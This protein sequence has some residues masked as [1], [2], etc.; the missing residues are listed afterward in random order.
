MTSKISCLIL[1]ATFIT[2]GFSSFHQE[3]KELFFNSLEKNRWE[4]TLPSKRNFSHLLD[5]WLEDHGVIKKLP[6]KIS[7]ASIKALQEIWSLRSSLEHSYRS[8]LESNT[9]ST[10]IDALRN[11]GELDSKKLELD[12]AKAKTTCAE[13]TEVFKK[14]LNEIKKAKLETRIEGLS[15]EKQAEAHETLESA[16]NKLYWCKKYAVE[17]QLDFARALRGANTDVKNI[18][19]NNISS[20][21]GEDPDYS[22]DFEQIPLLNIQLIAFLPI[23]EERAKATSGSKGIELSEDIT[24]AFKLEVLS[25]PIVCWAAEEEIMAWIEDAIERKIDVRLELSN[26]NQSVNQADS[27]DSKI[28]NP[29][30]AKISCPATEYLSM[31]IATFL[32]LEN[33]ID[34]Y[35]SAREELDEPKFT[36]KAHDIYLQT[37]KRKVASIQKELEPENLEAVQAQINSLEKNRDSLEKFIEDLMPAL[38]ESFS[39]H[40]TLQKAKDLA[41]L[42]ASGRFIHREEIDSTT[43]E[44]LNYYESQKLNEE[45]QNYLLKELEGNSSRKIARFKARIVKYIK[46][47]IEYQQKNPSD[48]KNE[49]LERAF[50]EFTY[51]SISY[52]SQQKNKKLKQNLLMRALNMFYHEIFKQ[53]IKLLPVPRAAF[54]RTFPQLQAYVKARVKLPDFITLKQILTERLMKPDSL[55]FS[56]PDFPE[57]LLF[58]IDLLQFAS[59]TKSASRID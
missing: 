12:I 46:L 39:L 55:K 17:A 56:Q 36:S 49:I 3:L 33:V 45:N 54:E 50:D 41:I 22:D 37:L 29:T 24:D 25:Q 48:K 7:L 28:N 58:M 38:R 43:S 31:E 11:R 5:Y 34:M 57:K 15:P 18:S 44:P 1:F 2:V 10:K 32:V 4:V 8:N 19:N 53:T 47:L 9:I 27:K 26:G 59:Y 21:I 6:A 51:L 42:V 52:F 40:H 16:Q 35:K 23:V 30:K 13:K 20:F 14:A